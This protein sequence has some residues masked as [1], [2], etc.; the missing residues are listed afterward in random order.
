MDLV[1]E[2]PELCFTL[3]LSHWIVVAERKLALELLEPVLQRTRHIHARIGSSQAPQLSDPAEDTS[4]SPDFVRYF[5]SVWARTMELNGTDDVS[6]TPEYGPIAD[7]YMPKIG[8]GENGQWTG[9]RQLDELI[10]TEAQTLASLY[11]K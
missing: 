4:E 3:D 5:R 2:L 7:N 6:M 9:R 8:K 11:Y 1:K 10:M